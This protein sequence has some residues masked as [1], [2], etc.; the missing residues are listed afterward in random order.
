MS[1]DPVVDPEP[2][3]CH[4]MS[5]ISSTC[6]VACCAVVT[7]ETASDCLQFRRGSQQLIQVVRDRLYLVR[8][9]GAPEALPAVPGEIGGT[10]HQCV[11]RARRGPPSSHL[12]AGDAVA[13]PVQI[14]AVG[15]DGQIR[16]LRSRNSPAPI[17][18][19]E[20]QPHR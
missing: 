11:G 17:R 13:V 14:V 4:S 3:V 2:G 1:S 18:E 9:Q 20:V 5:E 15:A 6:E 7:A 16:A 19:V 12:V 8:V 10:F